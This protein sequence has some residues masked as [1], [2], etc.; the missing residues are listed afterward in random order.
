MLSKK[1]RTVTIDF[2]NAALDI[3]TLFMRVNIAIEEALGDMMTT[4][5][6]M[7]YGATK[8]EQFMANADVKAAYRNWEASSQLMGDARMPF[9]YGGIH[10][11][12]YRGTGLVK[13]EPTEAYAV[14]LGVPEM[15]KVFYAPADYTETVNQLGQPYYAKAE[16]MK[17]GKGFELEAQTNPLA[18]NAMP[19]AVIKIN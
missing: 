18:L 14:P 2:T 3:R 8:W 7:F 15:F 6:I 13:I 12:R 11:E 19:H 9:E 16:P 10:H 5:T 17:F 1:Q 4:G